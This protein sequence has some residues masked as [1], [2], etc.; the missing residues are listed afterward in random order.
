[1]IHEFQH[2][3]KATDLQRRVLPPSMGARK[4]NGP[5]SSA[6]NALRHRLGNQ[7]IQRLIGEIS[8][9]SNGAAPLRSPAVRTNLTISQ[10]GDAH[11]QEA[12]RVADAVMRMPAAEVSEGPLVPRPASTTPIAQ[13]LCAECEEEQKKSSPQVQRKERTSDNAPV[14]T[15]VVANIQTLQ[16]RGSPLPAAT[17]AFFEPRF[18]V[19]FSKVRVHVQRQPK[20]KKKAEKRKAEEKEKPAPAEAKGPNQQV[21]VVRDKDLRLGGTLVKDLK[22][23]KGE[24]MATKAGTDWTLV[25]SMHGSE[26]R[27]G[28]QSGPDWQ[29][30]AIFYEAA[31][32]EKLFNGDKDF[33][34][35][36][37][38]YG[39]TYLS[40]ISCQVSASFEGTLISNLTRA[41]PGTQRQPARGLGARCKPIAKAYKLDE[42]PKTRA[43]FEK[44]PQ[45]KQD[46][47]RKQLRALNDEWGYYGAPPVPDDKAVHYYYDEEPKGEWVKVEVMIGT[48]H[49][50]SDLEP[51]GIPYWNRTTG[52]KSAEFRRKCD[53]GVGKLKRE[54]KSTVPDVSE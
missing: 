11:E 29:K 30:N 19:D 16:G 12:D 50:V 21:Y 33:V 8:G 18:G 45:D 36:R 43:R 53:Q 23:F 2:D 1:M 9:N 52:D 26:D 38:Q 20:D 49:R 35:W 51:T 34:K 13:R 15:S 7:G 6:A 27:L 17:R 31:D 14:T 44:L 41:A 54:H 40:L 47:I 5:E 10:P 3:G 28:A 25:L 32:I 24:V 48:G 22:D 39:P 46:S 42:A 4:A 37:D